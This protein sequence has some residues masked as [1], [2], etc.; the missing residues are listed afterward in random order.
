M[1]KLNL[2]ELVKT[3]GIVWLLLSVL[4]VFAF[5]SYDYLTTSEEV[6]IEKLIA[7]TLPI[8]GG[9][10]LWA[11]IWSLLS[12]VVRRKLYFYVFLT[13]TVVYVLID[14]FLEW[15]LGIVAYNVINVFISEA[16]SYFTGGL[17]LAAFFYAS[18]HYA[19][20]ISKRRKFMFANLFSLGIGGSDNI[21]CLCQ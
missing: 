17:L 3:T 7:G 19:L 10:L 16:L 20:A 6:H 11:A 5:A 14:L 18:M 1:D 4:V 15:L 12:Y 8:I 2:T 9:V 21:C 13:I